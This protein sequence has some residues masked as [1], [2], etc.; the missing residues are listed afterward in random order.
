MLLLRGPGE[1]NLSISGTRRRRV[2]LRLEDHGPPGREDA[3]VYAEV[4]EL[5]EETAEDGVDGEM[6]PIG[7]VDCGG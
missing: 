7:Q 3:A 4:V 1:L 5:E 2:V 6:L